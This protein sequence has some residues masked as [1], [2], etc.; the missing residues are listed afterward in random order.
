MVN[1]LRPLDARETALERGPAEMI[2]SQPSNCQ[3]SRIYNICAFKAGCVVPEVSLLEAGS[4]EEALHV[5]SSAFAF[6]VR[7]VWDRHRL[8]AV[9]KPQ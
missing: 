3:A 2:E 8:V 9:L 6:A 4:D 1:A 5:A 7:E